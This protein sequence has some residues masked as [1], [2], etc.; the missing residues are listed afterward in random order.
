M[1]FFDGLSMFSKLSLSVVSFLLWGFCLD[2]PAFSLLNKERIYPECPQNNL[3][4]ATFLLINMV[5]IYHQLQLTLAKM[6]TTFSNNNYYYCGRKIVA[7]QYHHLEIN[8]G[9][10]LLWLASFI[11]LVNSYLL[12]LQSCKTWQKEKTNID[13][14]IKNYFLVKVLAPAYNIIVLMK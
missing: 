2:T 3:E 10:M 4:N 11:V 6:P 13:H 14:C 7:V 12:H 1:G 9:T 8:W 5:Y